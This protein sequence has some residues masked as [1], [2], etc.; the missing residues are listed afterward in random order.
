LTPKG[1]LEPESL[2]GD[3]ETGRPDMNRWLIGP[4]RAG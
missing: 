2:M 3:G 4:R 1:N